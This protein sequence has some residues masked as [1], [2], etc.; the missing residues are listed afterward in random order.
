[1]DERESN[2][3]GTLLDLICYEIDG[4]RV[5]FEMEEFLQDHLRECA[6]CRKRVADYRRVASREP[7]YPG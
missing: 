7:A 3:L 2:C 5:S 4:Q 6:S 1:M